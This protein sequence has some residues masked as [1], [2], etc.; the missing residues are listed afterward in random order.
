MSVRLGMLITV[1][2]GAKFP[3]GLVGFAMRGCDLAMCSSPGDKDLV[4]ILVPESTTKD[5]DVTAFKKAIEEAQEPNGFKVRWV[6]K[7]NFEGLDPLEVKGE[8]E[9]RIESCPVPVGVSARAAILAFSMGEESDDVANAVLDHFAGMK[10]LRHAVAFTKRGYIE[11]EYGE[12]AVSGE[13]GP[14][15]SMEARP[16][17]DHGPI[18]ADDIIDVAKKLENAQSVDDFLKS[19]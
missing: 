10:G 11:R 15:P 9:A 5:L 16:S 19:I 8:F 3:D 18:T 13:T 14:Q 7:P 17:T 2:I 6:T 12:D 1:V 4:Y